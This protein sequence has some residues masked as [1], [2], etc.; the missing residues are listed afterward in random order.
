M[1]LWTDRVPV[2]PAIPDDAA[3]IDRAF[4]RLIERLGGDPL[5]V[6]SAALVSRARGGGHACLRLDDWADRPLEAG[7]PPLPPLAAWRS[8]LGRSPMIS[9]AEEASGAD[10]RPLVLDG[11]R[12]YLLRYWRA[13]TSLAGRIQERLTTPAPTFDR[14]RAARAFRRLFPEALG[15]GHTG[16]DRQAVAAALA[17]ER[18]L[19][20]IAGGPGTG[21]TTTIARLLL[22]LMSATTGRLRIRLA[23]PT[24]KAAARMIE[25]LRLQLALPEADAGEPSLAFADQL[26]QRAATLHRLLGYDPSRDRFRHGRH[27]PLACD[28]LIVD[29]ASMVDLLLMHR[30][31]D[32]L[33]PHARLVLLG[34]PHQLASVETG[35]VFGD[36]WRAADLDRERLPAEAIDA[37]TRL[38][39][40]TAGTSKEHAEPARG[41]LSAAGVELRRTYRFAD[42]PALAELAAAVRRGD[43]DGALSLLADP[44]HQEISL[45]PLPAGSADVIVPLDAPIL[46][47]LESASAEE[48]LSE[49]ATFRILCARRLGR[50]SV[51]ALG[52]AIER[53]LVEHGRLER[54]QTW[55]PGRPILVTANDHALGLFNGDLG[56]CWPDADGR[57]WVV[58]PTA[59]PGRTRRLTP[60]KLPRH[61]TAWAMTVHKSQ[62]S[63]MDRV[64][65]VLPDRDQALLTRELIYT[66]ATRARRRLEI[67]GDADLLHL[68][69][70]RAGRRASGL[71]ERLAQG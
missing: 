44:T 20:L 17:L 5:V 61:A 18:S 60:A 6:A 47:V 36:L 22:L 12:L 68:A 14:E 55:Y 48:A 64:A 51:E 16:P 13:E 24:G 50:W 27:Q 3:A 62:G 23:A 45:R 19:T 38:N 43:A 70:L 37:V 66:G 1:S 59:E 53:R 41:G 65:L 26:P 52:K 54:G 11:D 8:H 63:E 33:P 35:A 34:D 57:S 67:V 10:A 28:L 56:I 31:F 9:G 2:A 39:L 7:G 42:V 25:S 32:A 71:A 58:F 21:K 29:E 49:L 46:R 69:I 30:M 40:A 4:A 15:A